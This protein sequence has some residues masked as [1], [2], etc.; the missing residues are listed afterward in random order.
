MKSRNDVWK[1][2]VIFLVAVVLW[3]LVVYTVLLKPEKRAEPPTNIRYLNEIDFDLRRA[4]LIETARRDIQFSVPE[5]TPDTPSNYAQIEFVPIPVPIY[6]VA[7]KNGVNVVV[8]EG[9]NLP[10]VPNDPMH[11]CFDGQ[12]R[13]VWSD[14]TGYIVCRWT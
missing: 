13:E 12:Q 1:G 5:K 14:S 8:L 10:R 2:L 4:N 11:P 7:E 9:Y 6:Y 3:S